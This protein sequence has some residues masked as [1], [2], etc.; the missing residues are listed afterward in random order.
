MA[1]ES[2]NIPCSKAGKRADGLQRYRCGNCGKTYSDH[3]EHD[4]LFG[5]KQAVDDAKALLALQLIVEGNS[6]RSTERITGLHRDTIMN[7]IV[8]AGERCQTLLDTKIH[9]IDV[10]DV[11]ADEIWT[12][13]AKKE[14]RRVLGDKN[15]E[16]IGDAWVFIAIERNSKLVLAFHLSKRNTMSTVQ[17]MKMVANA[18]SEKRYQLTTDGFV[19]YNFAVGTELDDRVDYAQL[20]KIYHQDSPEEQRRYSPAHLAEAVKTP[21]YGV[22]DE[23]KICTSHV[24]RQ[25]GSLRLWCKRFTRLTYCFS[26]KWENLRAALALHFAYYDFCRVHSTIRVT[27]AMEAGITDHVW[28]LAELLSD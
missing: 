7:L 4:N 26:K 5:T 15:Y 24:E 1:C 11:Q 17:F 3:K 19:G 16:H 23:S 10:A 18:T 27:P 6:I 28:T 9:N 13:V 21:V 25:N 2:C 22:P 14:K 12:Y 8:A 20:V